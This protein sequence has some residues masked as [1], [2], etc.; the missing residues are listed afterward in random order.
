MTNHPKPANKPNWTCSCSLLTSINIARAKWRNSRKYLTAEMLQITKYHPT[1]EV[2]RNVT[3]ATAIKKTYHAA[4]TISTTS[5][6]IL[7]LCVQ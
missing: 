5:A 7:R 2:L 4:Q 1:S 6:M 3:A